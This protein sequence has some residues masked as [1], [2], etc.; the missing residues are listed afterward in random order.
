MMK[1]TWLQKYTNKTIVIETYDEK[2]NL[3][4]VDSIGDKKKKRYK[5]TK[6]KG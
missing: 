4:K 1:L 2:G 6:Q 3:I 5:L